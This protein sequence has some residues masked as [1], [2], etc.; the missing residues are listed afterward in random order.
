MKNP[1]HI[2][3]FG[4]QTHAYFI[5]QTDQSNIFLAEKKAKMFATDFANEAFIAF[6]G[7]NLID[8]DNS[9]INNIK[10]IQYSLSE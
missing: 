2:K 9:M 4:I 3:L 8:C 5:S 10:R 1:K 7:D 6:K